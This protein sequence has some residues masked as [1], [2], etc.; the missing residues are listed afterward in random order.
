MN[1]VQYFLEADDDTYIYGDLMFE[2]EF[3]E[4]SNTYIQPFFRQDNET[5]IKFYRDKRFFGIYKNNSLV[6]IIKTMT[7]WSDDVVAYKLKDGVAY[8]YDEVYHGRLYKK[9][10]ICDIDFSDFIR[11]NGL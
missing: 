8:E 9:G 1:V 2:C 3:D 10:E 6:E 7:C 5:I 4:Q 11:A